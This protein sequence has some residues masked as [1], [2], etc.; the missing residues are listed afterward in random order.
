V[1]ALDPNDTRLS[2][3]SSVGPGNVYVSGGLLA[4]SMRREARAASRRGEEEHDC[5]HVAKGD[6]KDDDDVSL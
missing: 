5:E 1:F 4:E 6:K 2:L 3:R